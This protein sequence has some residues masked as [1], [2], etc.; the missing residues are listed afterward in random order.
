MVGN[1]IEQ[2]GKGRGTPKGSLYSV[3]D[4]KIEGGSINISTRRDEYNGRTYPNAP[5]STVTINK[6]PQILERKT[7]ITLMGDSLVCDYYGG[8]RESDLGSNQTGWGQQL[9]NL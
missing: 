9:G 2:T 3:N 4:I 8:R 5:I 1:N 6:V 7:K